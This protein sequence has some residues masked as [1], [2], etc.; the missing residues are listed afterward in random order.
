MP[1][2]AVLSAASSL[3]GSSRGG[4]LREVRTSPTVSL[5][6]PDEPT[7]HHSLRSITSFNASKMQAI[8]WWPDLSKCCVASRTPCA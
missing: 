3:R 8:S 4:L 6:I 7:R 5:E 2:L 1:S